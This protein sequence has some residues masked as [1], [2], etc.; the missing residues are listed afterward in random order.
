MN[1]R[2][3]EGNGQADDRMADNTSER[4]MKEEGSRKLRK[5]VWSERT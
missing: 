1:R 5:A 4:L 2:M 3:N